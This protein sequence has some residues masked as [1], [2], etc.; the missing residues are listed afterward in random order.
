VLNYSLKIK[1]LR[2]HLSLTQDQFATDLSVSRSIIS[3]IEIGKFN[4]TLELL[5]DIARKYNIDANYFFNENFA[6]TLTNNT[7]SMNCNNCPFERINQ[8]LEEDITRYREDIAD[9]KD[10]I[11]TLRG[12]ETPESKLKN[13]S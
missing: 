3:Q 9:L 5:N 7:D 11:R 13:V 8:R 10:Q 4:P 6:L 2:K 12:I 1:E